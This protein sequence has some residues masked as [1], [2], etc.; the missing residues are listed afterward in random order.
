MMCFYC[1]MTDCWWNN[2]IKKFVFFNINKNQT[3]CFCS[4][5][6]KNNVEIENGLY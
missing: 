5:H 6:S 4:C 3:V 2:E 1:K